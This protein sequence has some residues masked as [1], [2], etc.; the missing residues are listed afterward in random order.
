MPEGTFAT[1]F[2]AI[3][4]SNTH[5]LKFTQAG[6]PDGIIIRTKTNEI[7]PLCSAGTLVG[8]F[9]SKEVSFGEGELELIVGDKILLYTDA[10]IEAHNPEG[11]MLG[12]DQFYDFLLN[13]SSIPIEELFELI[14]SFGLSYSNRTAYDDD[15]T[16]VGFEVLA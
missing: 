8:A 11:D 5:K 12:I 1:M 9:S 16:L 2:Y 7:I 4:D 10:I 15:F 13:N 6:H 3:Y 14:Y